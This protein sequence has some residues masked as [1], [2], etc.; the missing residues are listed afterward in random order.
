MARPPPDTAA[1]MVEKRS[2]MGNHWI[3]LERGNYRYSY[4]VWLIAYSPLADLLVPFQTNG[5]GKTKFC[6]SDTFKKRSKNTYSKSSANQGI[7]DYLKKF[8]VRDPTDIFHPPVVW[9]ILSAH[10]KIWP[11]RIYDGIR[12]YTNCFQSDQMVEKNRS[13]RNAKFCIS[14]TF[15]M[16]LPLS[17][18]DK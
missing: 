7:S 6:I 4:N 16:I 15:Q 14:D 17:R 5:I 9:I 12:P 8:L 18:T 11:G 3:L 2:I 10:N 13:V 1:Q